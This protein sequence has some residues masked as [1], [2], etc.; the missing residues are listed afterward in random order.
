MDDGYLREVNLETGMPQVDAAMKRLVFELNRSVS[1]GAAAV[2]LVHGYGSS[3]TGGKIRIAVRRYL[4]NA[5]KRGQIKAYITGEQFSIFDENTRA[6]FLI[7]PVL[8]RDRDL[9]SHN[10]G[11][12]IVIL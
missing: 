9:E 12:T 5:K 8:R 1:L 2:K 6:A 10:N 3:G 4:E 7:C 11:I